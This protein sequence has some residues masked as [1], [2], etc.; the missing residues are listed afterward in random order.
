MHASD[1]SALSDP[2]AAAAD[3][4]VSSVDGRATG[5]LIDLSVAIFKR[6]FFNLETVLFFLS[7]LFS[8][9]TPIFL[10]IFVQSTFFRGRERIRT[11]V[12]GFADL[13]LATRPL[14]PLFRVCKCTKIKF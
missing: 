14:D 5:F 8:L 1:K 6:C 3:A 12:Q 11:A 2:A 13:C 10:K 9:V 4:A 7:F